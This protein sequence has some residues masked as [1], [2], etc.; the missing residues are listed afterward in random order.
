MRN[1]P[2]ELARAQRAKHEVREVLLVGGERNR[3]ALADQQ[4]NPHDVDHEEHD[5]S[6][7][8]AGIGGC[9][10]N[11]NDRISDATGEH[12]DQA[13][14]QDVAHRVRHRYSA[15]AT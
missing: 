1:E 14:P 12:G 8:I 13:Q 2:H 3:A 5:A 10:D 11:T 9:G 6:T 15:F 4:V 7:A